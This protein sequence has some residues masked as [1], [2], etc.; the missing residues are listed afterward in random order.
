VLDK[1]VSEQRKISVH[2]NV[3]QF[4]TFGYAYQSPIVTPATAVIEG[5]DSDLAKV[6]DVWVWVD[7]DF[8]GSEAGA[9]SIQGYYNISAMDAFGNP[10]T[11]VT[12]SPT[13]ARVVIPVTRVAAIKTM[14][15]SPQIV[16]SPS[17]PF[18]I[19]SVT[20]DPPMVT[21]SGPASVLADTSI[22]GTQAID[23]SGVN[24]N[25]QRSVSLILPKSLV[26]K[27]AGNVTVT[28]TISATRPPSPPVAGG[29]TLHT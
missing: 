22:I 12:V 4:A 1:L 27:P 29:T 6:K 20:V 8:S 21:I 19:K 15:V 26:A 23:V 25:I 11:G 9:L 17:Y 10:V 14:V 5:T 16:G 24:G 13:Q 3:T 18:A 2:M 28:V 7:T